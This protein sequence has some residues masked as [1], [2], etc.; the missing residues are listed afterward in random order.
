[1]KKPNILIFQTDQQQAATISPKHPCR[2]PNIQRLAGEGIRFTR[3][4]TPCPLCAPARASMMTS[5]YPHAHGM[6]NNPH[7]PQAV[8]RGL[9]GAPVMFSERLRDA[10]YRMYFCGKWH[11]SEEKAPRDHGWEEPDGETRK[12]L[13]SRWPPGE[14]PMEGFRLERE[15]W[16]PYWLYGKVDAG[17]EAFSEHH[18]TLHAEEQ[19]RRFSRSESPWCLYLGTHG[20]HDPFVAPAEFGAMYDPKVVPRPANYDDPLTDKPAIYR[21]MREE[22]WKSV[23]WKEC[24][25]A[26]AAYWASITFLD[27]LV[28]RMMA[29]LRETRQE[30]NTLFV[31][32]SDHGEMMGGHGLFFKGIMPFEECWRVPLVM[33]WPSGIRPNQWCDDFVS[34]L[35]LG[36]TLLE[37]GLAAALP[38]AHGRSLVPLLRGENPEGWPQDFYGQYFG[39]ETLCTQHVA[40]TRRYKYVFNGFDFDELYDLEKDPGEMRNLYHSPDLRDRVREMNALLW[41][42]SREAGCRIL[43]D[44]YPTTDIMPFGPG[45]EAG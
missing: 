30:E 38:G 12:R 42:R 6:L 20:P 37:L 8:R 11:V 34:L 18:W 3:A 31:F 41:R 35:D 16:K 15:G 9:V 23:G 7:V 22:L 10:G 24:S 28:G 25:E 14:L 36:P 2:T 4:Y 17:P 1:M 19:V 33:R 45:V 43:L 27:S 21:R 5:L 26:T 32:T 29:V 39:S 44:G 40:V 13:W